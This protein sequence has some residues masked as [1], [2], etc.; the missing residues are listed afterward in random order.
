M[1]YTRAKGYL[2]IYGGVVGREIEL[3]GQR[4]GGLNCNEPALGGLSLQ[5]VE[6]P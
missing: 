4:E 2:S 5:K 1:T 6:N 3:M